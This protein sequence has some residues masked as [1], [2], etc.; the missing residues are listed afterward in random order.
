ML[1][2]NF[3]VNCPVTR[4]RSRNH[5]KL[6][7]D[8]NIMGEQRLHEKL[9]IL[10]GESEARMGAKLR[11]LSQKME[12]LLQIATQS[13]GKD[14]RAKQNPTIAIQSNPIQSYWQPARIA[15]YKHRAK[16]QR[17]YHMLHQAGLSYLR[18]NRRSYN[19][20]P[21]MQAIFC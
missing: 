21:S 15:H 13:H 12:T 2:D 17:N 10:V 20:I 6:I 16:K 1:E 3:I 11:Q 7:S 18:R 5:N 14:L 8:P 19:M 4:F 9:K